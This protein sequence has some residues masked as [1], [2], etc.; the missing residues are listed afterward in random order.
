M[1]IR[2]SCS[3]AVMQS[4]A[5][6][7][8]TTSGPMIPEW[9]IA[10]R[11]SPTSSPTATSA[12]CAAGPG[13][14]LRTRL[15]PRLRLGTPSWRLCRPSSPRRAGI[16]APSA[17]GWRSHQDWMPRQSLGTRS[18]ESRPASQAQR[19]ASNRRWFASVSIDFFRLGEH[20]TRDWPR[21]SST[22]KLLRPSVSAGA[23]APRDDNGKPVR[24][25]R[26]CEPDPTQCRRCP[27]NGGR[28][29]VAAR[30]HCVLSTD[31][32]RRR[33]PVVSCGMF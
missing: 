12:S 16:L 7:G 20:F 1:C 11:P 27:R 30:C 6:I 4:P 2:T 29:W 3:I 21:S 26:A 14:R 9:K 23:L 25:D 22:A 13:D 17:L 28:V 24:V 18:Q 10:Q 19:T 32:G 8:L 5:E 15:V 33:D 31:M